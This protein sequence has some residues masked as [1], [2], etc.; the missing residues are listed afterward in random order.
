MTT[1]E[2]DVHVHVIDADILVGVPCYRDGAMVAKALTSMQTDRIQLLI[3]DNGS[4]PDVKAVLDGRGIVLRNPVNRYVNPAWNQM[5]QWF[6]DSPQY[7]LLVIANSDLVLDP[8]WADKLR[9]YR[10]DRRSDQVIFG[11]VDVDTASLGAFFAM[12]RG[13]VEACHPIPEDLLIYGGDDFI[14]EIAK[15]VG[16]ELATI[17]DLTMFHA[18]SGT[19]KKSPEVWEIG[20]RDNARW[21]HHVLPKIVPA[22]VEEFLSRQRS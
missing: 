4:D 22:R 9:A 11:K 18:V 16:F 14:F 12:T 15:R 1:P 8:G 6:L 5:M 2:I 17:G 10:R 20:K 3:V 19:I 13:A 7:D 21:H